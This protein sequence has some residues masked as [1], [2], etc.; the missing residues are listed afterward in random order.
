MPI[1]FSVHVGV[2]L[3]LRPKYLELTVMDSKDLLL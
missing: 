3:H 2:N 1:Y